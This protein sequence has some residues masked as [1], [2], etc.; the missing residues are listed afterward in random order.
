MSA[1]CPVRG[2]LFVEKTPT[3]HCLPR[4]GYLSAAYCK[5]CFILARGRVLETKSPGIGVRSYKPNS[6]LCTPTHSC[7]A[8][9]INY[10]YLAA[11][12]CG[13]ST[14]GLLKFRFKFFIAQ[15]SNLR[16]LARFYLMQ[17]AVVAYNIIALAG[18][19]AV[20]KFVVILALVTNCHK[21]AGFFNITF[22]SNNRKSS[23]APVCSTPYRLVI[24]SCIRLKFRSKQPA[25]IYPG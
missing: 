25:Q 14:K 23:D 11:N 24:C 17:V 18:N 20:Y 9:C 19:I 5:R 7:T 10:G 13:L 4:R 15:N 3:T 2:Y 8:F 21:K 6:V 16:E 1:L 22:G 12:R